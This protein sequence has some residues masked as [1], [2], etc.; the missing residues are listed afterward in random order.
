MIAGE[1]EVADD[2]NLETPSYRRRCCWHSRAVGYY[3]ADKKVSHMSIPEI[4][5]HF[6]RKGLYISGNLDKVDSKSW[7]F[8]HS[9]LYKQYRKHRSSHITTAS[10]GNQRGDNDNLKYIDRNRNYWLLCRTYWAGYRV[11]EKFL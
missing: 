6:Y 7:L 8:E 4:A 10:I 3:N 1:R 5:E 11:L 9:I 2:K